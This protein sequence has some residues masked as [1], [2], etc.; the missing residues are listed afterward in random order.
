MKRIIL[1]FFL[2][3]SCAYKQI[4]DKNKLSN[5]SFSDSLSFEQFEQKLKEYA[6]N[7]PYPDINK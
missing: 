3:S 4:D 6:N 5:I 1:L 7:N 2:F